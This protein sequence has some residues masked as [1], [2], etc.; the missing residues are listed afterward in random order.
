MHEAVNINVSFLNPVP[1]LGI[2]RLISNLNPRAIGLLVILA[3][4]RV[5]LFMTEE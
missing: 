3:I 1:A 5:V 2:V 4:Q